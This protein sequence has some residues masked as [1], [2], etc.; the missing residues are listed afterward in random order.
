MSEKSNFVGHF[1]PYETQKGN[2]IDVENQA[3][4]HG[5]QDVSTSGLK[6]NKGKIVIL[7]KNLEKAKHAYINPMTL[8][9]TSNENTQ[10]DNSRR[11]GLNQLV[12]SQ[13]AI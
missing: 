5:S 11:S 4:E 7:K 10:R 8:D 13:H 1:D 3:S 6:K 2:Q 12:S 9:S